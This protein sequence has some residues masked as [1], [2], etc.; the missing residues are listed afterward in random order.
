MPKI[1]NEAQSLQLE[2]RELKFE[3]PEKQRQNSDESLLDNEAKN[4][5]WATK[6]AELKKRERS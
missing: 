3:N 2:E 4:S 5:K 1:A 6:L